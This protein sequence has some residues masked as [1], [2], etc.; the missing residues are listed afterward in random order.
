MEPVRK[1]L[2]MPWRWN[3]LIWILI[4]TVLIP[5]LYLLSYPPIVSVQKRYP[6]SITGISWAQ[7]WFVFVPAD[8]L[9]DHSLIRKPMLAWAKVWGVSGEFKEASFWRSGELDF[10]SP[11]DN[12][13]ATPKKSN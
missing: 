9:I 2:L 1:L 5:P 13:P 3:R 8:W 6:P 11:I 10:I 4:A 7:G 12:T